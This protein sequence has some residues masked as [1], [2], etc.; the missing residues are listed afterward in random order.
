MAQ[1]SATQCFYCDRL[2][3]RA[4]QVWNRHR[5]LQSRWVCG[6]HAVKQSRH[7]RSRH[8]RHHRWGIHLRN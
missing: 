6:L 5:E 7:R 2:A 4:V 3:V 1:T 8:R